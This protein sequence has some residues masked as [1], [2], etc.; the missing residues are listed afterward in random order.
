MPTSPLKNLAVIIPVA[1]RERAWK[2]LLSDLKG[3]PKEAEVILVGP[4]EPTLQL[5]RFH[6]SSAWKGRLRW[7]DSAEDRGTQLNAGAQATRK[8][9]L[10]F[11]HA[12]TRV[13]PPAILA[14]DQSLR[15][16]SKKLYYFDL[17]F[18]SDGPFWMWI[19]EIGCWFRS[20]LLSV[21]FGDQGFCVSRATFR[22]I[23][24]FPEEV[25]YGEDHLFVWRAR[26]RGIAL[27]STGTIIKTS[28]RRYAQ[29]GWA[30]LTIR[31][32]QLWVRQAVPEWLRLVRW[33]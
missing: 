18:L 6:Q 29:T 25:S 12:D 27:H 15:S 33:V 2:N 7:V 32:A 8:R 20:R 9:F 30:R 10:W 3:L 24:G 26:Q 13:E 14:L 23:E 1:S 28:A 17:Q 5:F 19:N 4:K 16:D 22:K 31:Y 21:P 11:L